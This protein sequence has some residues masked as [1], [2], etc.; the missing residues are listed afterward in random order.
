MGKPQQGWA[1]SVCFQP[2]C[3]SRLFSF[4]SSPS[5]GSSNVPDL[6][7][8]TLITFK[9]WTLR[10]RESTDALPRLLL[11]IHGLTGDENSMWVFARD[12]PSQYWM[13]APRAPHSSQM[14]QGGY[15][16]RLPQYDNMDEV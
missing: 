2:F 10:V 8:T 1:S 15:S 13:I 7:N 16:W 9:D 14:D 3:R 4:S 12:L 5:T 11:L 6:N